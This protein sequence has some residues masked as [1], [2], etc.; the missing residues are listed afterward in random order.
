MC[1]RQLRVWVLC[2]VEGPSALVWLMFP[3]DQILVI[4]FFV[5]VLF[6][7]QGNSFLEEIAQKWHCGLLST[8]HPETFH[9]DLSVGDMNLDQLVRLVSA[10]LLDYRVVIFHFGIDSYFLGTYSEIVLLFQSSPSTRH[11]P[12]HP[13]MNSVWI[14]HLYED[15]QI[16]TLCNMKCDII[17][18]FTE[19]LR[20]AIVL[21]VRR[22]QCWGQ[23]CRCNNLCKTVMK[24]LCSW[25]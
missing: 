4:H 6:L 2:Y 20:D 21:P 5:C 25:E 22:V 16:S 13:G 12:E 19:S 7:F 3:R 17:T 11:L 18:G 24:I 15:C 14:H 23:R 8:S 10:G 1:P 9:G